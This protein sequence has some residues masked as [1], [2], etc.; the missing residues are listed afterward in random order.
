MDETRLTLRHGY[1]EAVA[2]AGGIPVLIPPTFKNASVVADAISGLLLSGGND[3]LPSY[4]GEA[5]LS[6]PGLIKPAPKERSDFEFALLSEVLKRGSPVLAVCYGMQLLNV[7]F[8]GSLYQDIG[9]QIEKANLHKEVRHRI[10]LVGGG[11]LLFGPSAPYYE[12]NSFHHQAVK[13]VGDGLE[14]FA[15]A[16]DGIVEGIYKKGYTFLV[17]VQWHPERGLSDGISDRIFG[18]F[19]TKCSV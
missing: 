3:L 13:R 14:V 17:G 8:G 12:V 4:Y 1:A 19:V 6:I 2:G 16:D 10:E 15:L 18:T 11:E 9:L 5:A 7:A